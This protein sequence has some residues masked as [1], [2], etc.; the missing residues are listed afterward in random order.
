MPRSASGT[1]PGRSVR[2]RPP[3]RTRGSAAASSIAASTTASAP[4]GCRARTR[5]T[6]ESPRAQKSVAP[7][8]RSS[9]SSEGDA[10]AVT[11]SPAAA[12]SSTKYP[13]TAPA[14]PVTTTVASAGSPS[15][16]RV[17]W[18]VSPFIGTVDMAT[19]SLAGGQGATAAASV[20]TRSAC[21]PRPP[22]MKWLVPATSAP[23]ARSTPPPVASTR[24]TSSMPP[25]NGG[26]ASGTKAAWSP[27]RNWT[28]PGFTV[29]ASTRTRTCPGP[30]S[31]AGTSRSVT[32][33]GPPYSSNPTARMVATGDGPGAVT[34]RTRRR[35]RST[36]P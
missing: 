21:D 26:T 1:W 16:S 22:G 32:T 29:A 31:G 6:S 33:S 30:G 9:C 8:A 2:N 10:T 20:T 28:S 23:S 19:G 11:W 13:P 24:P 12:A 17:T 34:S 7:I 27:L 15:S 3:S 14:A 35:R 18:A 4:P 5:S 25:Q 36:A